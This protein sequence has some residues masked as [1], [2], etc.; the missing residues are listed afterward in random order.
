MERQ[1]PLFGILTR[2]ASPMPEIQAAL[3]PG[4]VL[5]AYFLAEPVSHRWTVRRD[6][7]DYRALPG[8]GEVTAAVRTWKFT[9]GVKK[10]I[11]VKV[12]MPFRQTFLPG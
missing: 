7:L 8:E 2:L 5:V 4:A 1:R 10:G 3:P 9:P 12:R 11:K 6:G